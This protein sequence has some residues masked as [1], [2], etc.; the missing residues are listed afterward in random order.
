MGRTSARTS[1]S[2]T[3]VS[4]SQSQDPPTRTTMAALPFPP[5]GSQ[6][7][8]RAFVLCDSAS[9]NLGPAPGVLQ[10]LGSGWVEA[11]WDGSLCLSL[12]GTWVPSFE[13]RC[14]QT[15]VARSHWATAPIHPQ[16][17]APRPSV[18]TSLCRTSVKRLALIA[19]GC[20]RNESCPVGIR[21][22]SV[23]PKRQRAAT[24]GKTGYLRQV[25]R[26]W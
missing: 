11:R 9:D 3:N 7:R 4:S 17:A 16:N 19:G 25:T 13:I 15:V 21:K 22:P 18:C 26:G 20:F 24:D 6:P 12:M 1:C 10:R 5:H 2:P 23:P 8:P 14:H